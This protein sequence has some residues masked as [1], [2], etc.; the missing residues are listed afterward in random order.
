MKSDPKFDPVYTHSLR[1]TYLILLTWIVFAIWVISYTLRYGYDLD[2]DNFST[3]IG[4][5]EWVF[6]G[7]GLPWILAILVTVGFAVFIIKDD[8]LEESK[9]APTDDL[10]GADSNGQGAS[11]QSL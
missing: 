6:W 11:N 3:V 9:E 7:I 4:I 5:P 1:E 10:E 8:P 2:P